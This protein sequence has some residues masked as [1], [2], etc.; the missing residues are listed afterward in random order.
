MYQQIAETLNKDEYLH[1]YTTSTD[2]DISISE[3]SSQKMKRR[4]KITEIVLLKVKFGDGSIHLL[5][6][7]LDSGTSAAMLLQKHVE[8]G[9][10]ISGD[11]GHSLC[12]PSSM[13]TTVRLLVVLVKLINTPF[14]VGSWYPDYWGYFEC[15]LAYRSKDNDADGIMIVVGAC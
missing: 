10:R 15:H 8:P 1:A 13:A 14:L 12:G 7:L 2:N 4:H 6:T 11:K 9:R 3:P 5:R